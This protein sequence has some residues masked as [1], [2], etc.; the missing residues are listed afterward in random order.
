[1]FCLDYFPLKKYDD[2]IEQL[3][4]KYNPNDPTLNS[5]L[6][7]RPNQTII[8]DINGDFEEKDAKLFRSFAEKFTNFRVIFNYYDKEKLKLVNG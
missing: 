7:S 4:I 3:K 1:M 6:E 2:T 5:F 8:I